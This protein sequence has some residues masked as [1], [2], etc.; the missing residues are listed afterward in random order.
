MSEIEDIRRAFRDAIL[1]MQRDIRD[2]N[3][4]LAAHVAA[5][6]ERSRQHD[7]LLAEQGASLSRL[8]WQFIGVG[9]A[10]IIAL[11]VK[12]IADE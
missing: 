5:C 3:V 10:L 1:A 8:F 4:A 7:Q 9:T 2:L 6:E 12:F 11:V